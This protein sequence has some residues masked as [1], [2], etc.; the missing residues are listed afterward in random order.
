MSNSKTLDLYFSTIK[1]CFKTLVC[2]SFVLMTKRLLKHDFGF[3][4]KADP[5]SFDHVSLILT[6]RQY[7]CGV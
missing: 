4:L 1:F 7:R 3:P 2:F 6:S 5:V